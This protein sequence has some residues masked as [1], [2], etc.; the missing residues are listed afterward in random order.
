MAEM[1]AAREELPLNLQN[2][3]AHSIYGRLD[4]SPHSPT[5]VVD[6]MEPKTYEVTARKGMLVREGV[7]LTTVEAR[8]RRARSVPDRAAARDPP[9]GTPRRRRIRAQLAWHP[10]KQD[11]SAE[12]QFLLALI[13][14]ESERKGVTQ[15]LRWEDR[16][17][18]LMSRLLS[19]RCSALALGLKQADVTVA[20]TKGRK[21]YLS[22]RS[23]SLSSLD[24]AEAKPNFNFN[25]SH[26]G[27]YVVIASEP[28][29]VCGVDVAAPD[30][31]RRSGAPEQDVE[32]FFGTM[33]DILSK[34]EWAYVRRTPEPA[35]M[36]ER[37][38]YFWSCKEA[39]TKARGDGLAFGLG[40]AEFDIHLRP[41][42]KL[43]FDATVAVDGK[44]LDNWR[45]AGEELDN[46]HIVT[47][48]RGPPEDIIDAQGEFKA[49]IGHQRVDKAHLD[50]PKPEFVVLTPTASLV[51]RRLELE[52]AL[53]SP[54]IEGSGG[55]YRR[56][57]RRPAMGRLRDCCTAWLALPAAW[58]AL[59]AL[60][61]MGSTL[62]VAQLCFGLLM[63]V[64]SPLLRRGFLA[65]V[66]HIYPTRFGRA[67]VW[68]MLF[69]RR[70]YLGGRRHAAPIRVELRASQA[71]SPRWKAPPADEAPR[72]CVHVVA[73]LLDNYAY[74]VVELRPSGPLRC[75]VVDPGDAGA[76]LGALTELREQHYASNYDGSPRPSRRPAAVVLTGFH[77]AKPGQRFRVGRALDIE[78]IPSPCHTKGHV[79]FGLLGEDRR[80]VEGLFTGDTLFCGGCGAPFEGDARDVAANFRRIWHRCGGKCLLFP[81]HEYSEQLLLEYF[82][83]A[84]DAVEPAAVRR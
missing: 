51:P 15:Y 73:G 70:Y 40:R 83:V 42:P 54:L 16:V 65:V 68:F 13:G 60:L 34:K 79:M 82:G 10:K 57:A 44:R 72:S 29:C 18:A 36:A 9:R 41:G 32:K 81:G 21:P 27:Q 62:G 64:A 3:A 50:A 11:K 1:A 53:K 52:P 55:R 67:H 76:V 75:V 7:E 17:R 58:V 37:F 78:V 77:F 22:Q 25:V 74:V 4:P 30:Q 61:V 2:A 8:R 20:R 43:A 69:V 6:G 45:F 71:R 24:V 26:E 56:L 28:F 35:A 31:F 59:A 48:A 14:E 47:V 19:R 63:L 84:A 80:T 49:T 5:S 12:F 46:G 39:F 33:R 23:R 66:R 38:R